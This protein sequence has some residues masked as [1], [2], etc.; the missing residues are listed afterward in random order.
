MPQSEANSRVGVRKSE[1]GVIFFA[2]LT[3]IFADSGDYK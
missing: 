1:V 2:G 3:N